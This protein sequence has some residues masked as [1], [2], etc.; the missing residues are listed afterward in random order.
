MTIVP[1]ITDTP[2]VSLLPD[3]LQGSV[4]S[5]GPSVITHTMQAD[6]SGMITLPDQG[7]SSLTQENIRDIERTLNEQIFGNS[8]GDDVHD[9]R[10]DDSDLESTTT[11]DLARTLASEPQ[12]LGA[13]DATQGGTAGKAE[14]AANLYES[15]G[16]DFSTIAMQVEEV[17]CGCAWGVCDTQL[18]L[19]YSYIGFVKST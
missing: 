5:S 13:T 14:Q 15:L 8:G 17:R 19:L 6:A 16:F 9:E 12:E 7:P 1:T 3:D 2:C 4:L 18:K 11:E 10:R